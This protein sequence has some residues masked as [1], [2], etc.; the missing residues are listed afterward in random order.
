MSEKVD[1][2]INSNL[3][4]AAEEAK[5][6]KEGLEDVSEAAKDVGK[7]TDKAGK[8]G[9]KGFAALRNGASNFGTALKAMGI[10]IIV[11]ALA[12]LAKGF[13]TNQKVMVKVN[14]IIGTVTGVVSAFVGVL[15][16]TYEWITASGERFDAFGKVVKGLLNIA[17]YPLRLTF[18]GLKLGVLTLMRAYEKS[19][20]GSGDTEKINNLT[21]S[22]NETKETI[23]DLTEKVKESGKEVA[24][25]FMEAVSEIGDAYN[26]VA[27]GTKKIDV[28]KIYETAEASAVLANKSKIAAAE[29]QGLIEKYDRQAELQRQ[30]RDDESKTFEERMLA[31]QELG[32]ILDEQSESMLKQA[33]I[34]IAAARAELAL[35]KENIDLQVALKEA[36]NERA[37]VE[38]QITG[39]RSEQMVNQVSLEKELL[40]V[41][42]E[43][44]QE[45]LSGLEKELLELENSYK[46]KLRMA[47]KA[48]MDTTAITEQYEK[49]KS[50][51][52]AENTR[53]QLAAYSGLL[54]NL[55][56][57]A[58]ENKA[59]AVA[60]AVI[61]TYVGANKAFAQGGMLGFVTAGSVIAA[62]LNNVR[63]IM[64]QDV[65]SGSGGDVNMDSPREMVP[66][67]TGAFELTG[68]KQEPVKAF[69]VESEITDS[70]AQMA[71]INR[72]STI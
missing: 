29:L 41:Q 19:F 11:G 14:A 46:E 39:F 67:N 9:G 63:Q 8:K 38:A 50:Q 48:G 37:A 35:D 31:N 43:I 64:K 61:D 17:L 60:Q 72:R 4:E 10:G 12:L 3:G 25:N 23:A 49:Q 20:L 30:I 65:G 40:E 28:K 58:G 44:R 7:E 51:I 45:G 62:G 52:V 47:E 42:N 66:R 24:G 6:L 53:T 27:E 18:Q 56:K 5:E 59:L 55:S 69:V 13:S 1:I 34:R 71:D 2:E 70:Q 68:M 26:H 57:L 15:V 22:I 32:R 33:D 21:K 36:I 16:D 54:G